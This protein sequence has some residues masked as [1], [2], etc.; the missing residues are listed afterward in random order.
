[1]SLRRTALTRKTELRRTTPMPRGARELK[2]RAA[3]T[4]TR[5]RDTGPTPSQRALVAE[6]AGYCCELCGDRL[7]DGASWTAGH[8]FHHRQPRGMGGTTRTS[9]NAATN[10]LLLCGSGVDGCHGFIEAHRTAAEEEG[11]IVRHGL[12]PADVPVT[13]HGGNV[14]RLLGMASV[15][16]L[17]TTDGEYQAVA[18]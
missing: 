11:W 14:A 8:S 6:R 15:R 9:A 10:L 3:R 2:A 4:I 16:V 5:K 18:A 17:L 1:M 7:H 13:V 12:D